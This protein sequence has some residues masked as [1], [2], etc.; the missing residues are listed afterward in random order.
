[1]RRPRARG[2]TS[3]SSEIVKLRKQDEEERDERESMLDL[4]MRHGAGDA[5]REG[6]EGGVRKGAGR[7]KADPLLATGSPSS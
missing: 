6:R 4:Y 3:R 2:L 7:L 1:L 5:G